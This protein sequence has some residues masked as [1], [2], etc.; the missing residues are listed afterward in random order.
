MPFSVPLLLSQSSWLK[1][2]FFAAVIASSLLVSDE[3]ALFVYL[4]CFAVGF[5]VFLFH[6][7]R[8]G[9]GAVIGLFALFVGLAG[10][11]NGVTVAVIAAISGA[12]I[13]MPLD[14]PLPVLSFLGTIPYSLYLVHTPINR[15][16]NL[17]VRPPNQWLQFG[18]CIAAVGVS[19]LAAVAL[20]YFIER[21]SHHR[22]K[23]MLAADGRVK[24]APGRQTA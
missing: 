16:I 22:A 20:W 10:L 14:R 13:L 18:S 6:S 15:A 3:R 2:G 21:P 11:N 12:L 9:A 5:A 1:A 19:L 7:R 24:I 17:A 23:K 8:I 4:P